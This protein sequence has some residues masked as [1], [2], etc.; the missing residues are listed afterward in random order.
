MKIKRV[1]GR[2]IFDSRGL[3]ALECEVVF[4]NNEIVTASVPSGTSI[5]QYE[6]FELRDESDR[7]EGMGLSKAIDIIDADIAPYILGKEPDAMQSDLILLELDGTHEKTKL[8]ANT[9]L[10]VSMAMYRAQAVN[11]GIELYELIASMCGFDSVRLPI[12]IF[13]VING[14]LHAHN[15]LSIQEFMVIPKG[16]HDFRSAIDA[17]AELFSILQE[18]I[19]SYGKRPCLGAEGGYAPN[20]D[21]ETQP[22]D[23]IVQAIE[24]SS[25]PDNY[26]TFG[27]DAAASE[28][29][30]VDK[31]LYHINGNTLNQEEL[32]RWYVDLAQEYPLFIIEDGLEQNDWEGWSTLTQ[33][34]GAQT[35]IVG[36]DLFAT[37]QDRILMGIEKY[38][39]NCAIIKPN[40][41]GTI[42]ETIQAIQLCQAHNM[43]TIISHRS[44]DTED[45]FIADLSVGTN[46]GQ[47]KAGGMS[48]SERIAK[49]NRLLRIEDRLTRSMM[50]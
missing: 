15:N 3:P 45:T 40:Q 48:R 38:A 18:V 37:N 47:I 36:D 9:M 19:L 35:Q 43:Y 17:T 44:G 8:G 2:E 27:I 34:L 50:E 14:G 26:F 12:P 22:L 16:A 33:L 20:C 42:T 30:N 31:N 46:A 1:I 23:F 49:Y 39:A 11:E 13:N 24:N 29:Y 32:I 21:Y 6:A 4:E 7:L 25:Y 28:W 5:G 10:A 41:I